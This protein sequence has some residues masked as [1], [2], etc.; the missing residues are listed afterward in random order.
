MKF[1]WIMV[2]LPLIGE[3]GQIKGSFHRFLKRRPKYLPRVGDCVYVLGGVSPKVQEVKFSGLSYFH[4]HL[5]LEPISLS[6]KTVLESDRFK[7]GLEKWQ[8]T[9]KGEV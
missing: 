1:P 8:W 9:N 6:Y 5:I 3:D 7:K 4:V 2:E